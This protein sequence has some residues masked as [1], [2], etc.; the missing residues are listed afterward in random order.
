MTAAMRD[1]VSGAPGEAEALE[2]ILA[3]LRHTE[4]RI[5][6][7]ARSTALGM[8]MVTPSLPLVWHVNALRVD[9]PAADAREIAAEAALVQAGLAHRKVVIHRAVLGR[10]LAAAMARDGWNVSRLLVMVRRRPPEPSR[11][12]VPGTEVERDAGAATLAAFRREQPFGWQEEAVR[13]LAAMDDRFGRAAAGRDFASPPDDPACCCRLYTDGRLAQIDEVGTVSARRGRGHASA[14][15]LAAVA[16]A[17]AA[18]LTP[19]FLLADAADWP[20]R[21]YRRLGFDEIGSIYEFLKLR[22]EATRP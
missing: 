16:A 1:N 22:V 7:E 2:R 6:D 8:A 10:R 14:A 5:C 13:Q 19:V 12:A 4:E 18:G 20:Q 17:D 11:L 3:F 15:V 21:L 9:D